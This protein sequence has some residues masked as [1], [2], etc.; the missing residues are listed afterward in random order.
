MLDTHALVWWLH[1]SPML[2]KAA[3]IAMMDSDSEILVSAAS[4]MEI[5]TKFRLEKWMESKW[6]ALNFIQSIADEG[7]LHLP[8][9][10]EHAA[11][12]GSLGIDHKDPFDRF[13]VAQAQIESLPLVSNEKLFDSFGIERIW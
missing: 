9:S 3:R 8:I 5:T 10:L 12:A 7:F 4:A 1:D 13:L 2:G 11:L 6:L